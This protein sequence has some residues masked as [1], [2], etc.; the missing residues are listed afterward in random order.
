LD[1]CGRVDAAGQVE[2]D[3][4]AREAAAQLAEDRERDLQDVGEQQIEPVGRATPNSIRSRLLLSMASG[5]LTARTAS[6]C[7]RRRDRRVRGYVGRALAG[8]CAPFKIGM[9][10]PFKMGI[11][12]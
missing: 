3:E 1:S 6:K 11:G 2:G 8:C 5:R 12:G 9:A 7:D 4:S 10:A